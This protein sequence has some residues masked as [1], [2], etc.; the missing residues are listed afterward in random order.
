MDN[1]PQSGENGTLAEVARL[2]S[3]DAAKPVLGTEFLSESCHALGFAGMQG[4]DL[5]FANVRLVG[6]DLRSMA[7]WSSQFVDCEF[8]G[9]SFRK[10]TLSAC[11]FDRCTFVNCFFSGADLSSSAFRDCRFSG[12]DFGNSQL[13]ATSFLRSHFTECRLNEMRGQY[14]TTATTFDELWWSGS[15]LV[16]A[17]NG[18]FSLMPKPWETDRALEF[19]WTSPVSAWWAP[20]R[21]AP[22]N[23]L[24]V[25]L[26]RWDQLARS[27]SRLVGHPLS[28]RVELVERAVL[29][30]ALPLLVSDSG[31]L[32]SVLD[33][34]DD[35]VRGDT[36]LDESIWFA[37]HG[38]DWFWQ[39]VPTDNR[40][41]Q[42]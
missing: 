8:D 18:Q 19:E 22:R 7:V 24:L 21:R 42:W 20:A 6:C 35:M 9:C 4:G 14:L 10:G 27:G 34:M 2:I 32:R 33:P 39:R 37:S 31:W 40:F 36:E 38:A 5:S 3:I 41:R 17:D 11:T 1:I 16:G 23:R 29:E 26:A 13:E 28:W 30:A 25:A 15:W 12:V